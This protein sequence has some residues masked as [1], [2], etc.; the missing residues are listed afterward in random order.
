M[1]WLC[2][3]LYRD[4]EGFTLVELMI[5]IIILAILTGIAVPSYMV[6]RDRARIAAAQ[7]ELKNIATALEMYYADNNETYPATTFAAMTTALETG[8]PDGAAYMNNVPDTDGWGNDYVYTLA[9]G[10]Y[11]LQS[12]G[13]DGADEGD[14]DIEIINGELQQ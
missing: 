12:Y 7:S 11:T 4:K 8:G 14:D 3:N 6:L 13:P 10:V 1:K 9:A 2:K 5:V